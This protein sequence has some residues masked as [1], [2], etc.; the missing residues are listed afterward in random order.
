MLVSIETFGCRCGSTPLLE[1]YQRSEFIATAKILKVLQDNK[2][3]DYH[4]IEIEVI[5]VYK[6]TQINR[7]KIISSLNSSCAFLPLENTSWLIFASK[8]QKGFLSF[9]FCSGSMQ[10][11]RQFDLVAYPNLDIK[12]KKSLDLKLDALNFLKRSNISTINKFNLIITNGTRTCIDDLKDFKEKNRFAVYELNVNQDLSIGNIRT[13]KGFN[14]KVLS[15][16]LTKCIRENIDIDT[17]YLNKIPEKTKVI[18]IYFYYLA[19][20]KDPSFISEW[21]L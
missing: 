1:K 7:I 8:D 15:Q 5:N 10:I 6:G 20:G 2:N 4:D 16:K 14:N 13:L 12:Y 9:G 11:D 17:K 21:D 18:L 19:E 3:E